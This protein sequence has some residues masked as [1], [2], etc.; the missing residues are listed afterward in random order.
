MHSNNSTVF[1]NMCHKLKH[2]QV[3]ESYEQNKE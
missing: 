1:K 3:S 2:L